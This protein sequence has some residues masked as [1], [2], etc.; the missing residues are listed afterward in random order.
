MMP[1]V[2]HDTSL[3]FQLATVVVGIALA[4][5]FHRRALAS[6]AGKI[7]AALS[8]TTVIL[9]HA[10]WAV[11]R[12]HYPTSYWGVQVAMTMLPVITLFVLS[13]APSAALRALA[14]RVWRPKSSSVP[15]EGALLSRR[16]VLAETSERPR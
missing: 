12:A 9:S 2:P 7:V 3:A 11:G 6:R 8:V 4:W 15:A 16:N 1:V 5:L 10:A 13:L 14:G